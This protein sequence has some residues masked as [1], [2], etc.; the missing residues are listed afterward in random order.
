MQH[1][2]HENKQLVSKTI[3]LSLRYATGEKIIKNLNAKLDEQHK[4]KLILAQRGDTNALQEQNRKLEIDDL[5]EEIEELQKDYIQISSEKADKV[6]ENARLMAERDELKKH[7]VR[8]SGHVDK[9]EKQMADEK[10]QQ[11]LMKKDIEMLRKD[12]QRF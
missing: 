10:L 6:K 1:Y 12:A 5:T 11:R 4:T 2:L 8:L 9:L 7:N 3:N